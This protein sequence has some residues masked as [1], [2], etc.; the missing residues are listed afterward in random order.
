MKQCITCHRLL[1][2]TAFSKHKNRPDG[3]NAECKTCQQ[4]RQ[5][6][7]RQRLAD[8]P[9]I[10]TPAT[11]MCQKCGE[12]KPSSEFYRD[13]RRK[14]GLD[15]YCKICSA[16]RTNLYR[17]RYLDEDAVR[18]KLQIMASQARARAKRDNLP[19][20]ISSEWLYEHFHGDKA[21]MICPILG[22]E[23]D[24]RVEQ[25]P[26]PNS[27]SLDKIIPELGYAEQCAGDQSSGQL[28]EERR[29]S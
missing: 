4:A 29:G 10:I 8:R 22:I 25:S 7:N 9:E 6:R 16:D 2:Y 21:V 1:P 17:Q 12:T 19:Y 26:R 18:F 27:P 3:L 24:W 28:H 11:E 20:S 5:R 23:L 15:R 13:R 14:C